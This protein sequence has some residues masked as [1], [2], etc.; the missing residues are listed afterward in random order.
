[1]SL[2]VETMFHEVEAWDVGHKVEST[3]CRPQCCKSA[4]PVLE[5]RHGRIASL[6]RLPSPCIFL[7]HFLRF[8][9]ESRCEELKNFIRQIHI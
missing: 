9:S 4:E 1:M 5:A 2:V 7:T 8:S 3:R 6:W